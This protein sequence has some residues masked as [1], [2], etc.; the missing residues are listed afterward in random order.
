MSCPL[1]APR[2]LI[3]TACLPDPDLLPQTPGASLFS[4]AVDATTKP[5]TV[6]I[7]NSAYK[8]S[9]S[10]EK[11]NPTGSAL[12]GLIPNKVD[13][14]RILIHK[15]VASVYSSKVGNHLAKLD[16]TTTASSHGDRATIEHP[17]FDQMLR[18]WCRDPDLCHGRARVSV[19]AEGGPSFAK[20]N[21]ITGH[22]ALNR[23]ASRS[24][25]AYPAELEQTT[26]ETQ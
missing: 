20:A 11:I 7:R 4:R 23:A 3:T 14:Y 8:Q 15:T 9:L 6:R 18:L 16:S 10:F 13:C 1:A 25:T 24:A 17:A 5:P 2:H 21:C 19:T 26:F 12:A 22:I